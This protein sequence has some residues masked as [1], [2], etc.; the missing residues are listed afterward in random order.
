MQND[1]IALNS[2][3]VNFSGKIAVGTTNNGILKIFKLEKEHIDLLT[4]LEGHTAPVVNAKFINNNYIVSI[5]FTGG[6]IIWDK[7]N[8]DNN[9]RDQKQN[10]A[11]IMKTVLKKL[12]QSNGIVCHMRITA[13]S[14]CYN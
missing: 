13:K 6:L 12:W 7:E 4:S 3:E 11:F 9:C 2:F 1:I 5:D 14:L 8:N 10:P